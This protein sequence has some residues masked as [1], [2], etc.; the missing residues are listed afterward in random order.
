MT[1]SKVLVFVLLNRK[2]NGTTLQG[3][4]SSSRRFFQSETLNQQKGETVGW[5]R[6]T[7]LYP[8][9]VITFIHATILSK[10]PNFQV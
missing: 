7:L 2:I 3:I 8:Q 1:I 9:N 4:S 5:S 6:K 10:E